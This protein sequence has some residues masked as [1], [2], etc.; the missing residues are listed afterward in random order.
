MESSIIFE[1][2]EIV[3]VRIYA[4]R[5]FASIL[6]SLYVTLGLWIGKSL[7][8]GGYLFDVLSSLCF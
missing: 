2:R 6:Y 1:Q 5:H 8:R 4:L 7:S 3:L